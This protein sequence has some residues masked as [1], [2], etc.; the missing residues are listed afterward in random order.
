[1]N[2]ERNS[3]AIVIIFTFQLSLI[4]Q[5]SI[6]STCQVLLYY[7]I[8]N[9]NRLLNCQ[10]VPKIPIFVSVLELICGQNMPKMLL[11]VMQ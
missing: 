9:T 3:S 10:N 2:G 5:L 7:S 1:M 8:L 4:Y 6:T 11:L